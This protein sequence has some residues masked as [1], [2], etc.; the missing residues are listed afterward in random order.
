M[1]GWTRCLA[2]ATVLL[3]MAASLAACGDTWRGLKEDTGQNME[4]TGEAI[5]KAG[6]AVKP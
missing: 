4:K 1:S 5:E 6:E 3:G 2:L